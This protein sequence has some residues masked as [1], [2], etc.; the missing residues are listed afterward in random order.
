MMG[1]ESF[2]RGE[3]RLVLE[4]PA[5]VAVRA[6][7]VS[8]DVYSDDLAIAQSLHTVSGD[9][10]I[11][12]AHGA[13]EITTTSGDVTA[14]GVR[15]ASASST[16]GDLEFS[17]VSGSLRARS[18]SGD[19]TVHG[20]HDS[21]LVRATSGDVRVD[22]APRGADVETGSGS[23]RIRAAAGLL[24]VGTS[25]GDVGL[26]LQT[27]LRSA[28]VTTSSGEIHV[29]LAGTLGCALEMHTA[30]GSLDVNV[31]VTMKRVSRVEVSGL[32]R[33]GT[34]PVTLRS[35]SGDITLSSGQEQE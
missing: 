5:T 27:P 26:T 21:L 31:P 11:Q 24:H 20:A 16:S 32:V 8:G 23:V 15:G 3:V 6:E 17:D 35:A 34:A 4:V 25:S 1:G 30:S 28:E 7:A 18:S 12:N 19:I 29:W 10:D 22:A 2:P 33:N 14:N 9:L 13:L